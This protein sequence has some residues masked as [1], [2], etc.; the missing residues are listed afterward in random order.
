[1]ASVDRSNTHTG[2]PT[3]CLYLRSGKIKVYIDFRDLNTCCPKD[4]FLLPITDV[5]IDNTR[6]FERM[7]STDE[8][9]GYNQI[10]TRMMRSICHLERNWG[11]TI[12]Q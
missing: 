5:M 4:E 10:C 1:M 3:L 12:T 6:G 11:Y 9:L 8:F 2:L 7:S